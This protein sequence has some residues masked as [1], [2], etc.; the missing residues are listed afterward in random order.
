MVSAPKPPD[1]YQT[2][3]AQ[4]KSN[5]DTAS[6]NAALNRVSTYTPYGNEVYSQSGKD[7]SGAP[8]WRNDISL[9]PEAKAQL[10]NQLKQN[11]Q[12][13]GLGF[14]LADQAGNALANPITPASIH[15]LTYSVATPGL[16]Q[17]GQGIQ[18]T[19]DFSGVPSLPGA[20][21][22]PGL[23]NNAIAASYQHQASFLDPRFA[24][25]QSD[26]DAKLANQ[27]I[28]VSSNPAAWSRSQGDFGRERAL[29]YSDALN[30]AVGQGQTL[31]NN[32]AQ[33]KL[34]A[35]Q[36]TAMQAL[37]SQAQSNQAQQQ[38]FQQQLAAALEKYNM[39]RDNAQ[40]GNA[41][42]AQD[43]AQQTALATLPLNELSAVRSGTQI[44]NP[45]FTPAPQAN[46]AG[47]DIAGLINK[48][49]DTQVANYNN[50]MS[51]LFGLGG[52]LI[53]AGL[54]LLKASDERLKRDIVQIGQHPLGIPEYEF[55]Y[56]W[57]D[58]RETGVMAQDV[59]TVMPEAVAVMP[60]GYYAVDYGMIG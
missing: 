32:L 26:L 53:S 44:Q 1:P 40:L 21:D 5:Q 30:T 7:T 22:Y 4:T 38:G 18:G 24:N 49:Y 45:S 25:E 23:V 3:A 59:L 14:T 34:Q 29:S 9:A 48:N 42:T 6:Y 37:M 35:N 60:S 27:G 28:N 19:A 54:P 31:Q 2:A 52:G 12:L 20:N 8:I 58:K 36:Q 50:T 33:Q 15:P 10:D 47:T 17:G 39:G 16:P 43:L 41:T 13:S 56:I 57:S 46:A 11:T 51:G 55:S